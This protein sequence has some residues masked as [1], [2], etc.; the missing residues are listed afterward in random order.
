MEA[1][2]GLSEAETEVQ[3]RAR[4]H[5]A[6]AGQRNWRLSLSGHELWQWQSEVTE[7][8][9]LREGSAAV[10]GTQSWCAQLWQ[11]QGRR[12]QKLRAQGKGGG[13]AREGGNMK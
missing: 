2:L 7:T 4:V 9:K 13:F 3:A 6:T 5:R 8:G 11:W 1:Q 12:R 10:A